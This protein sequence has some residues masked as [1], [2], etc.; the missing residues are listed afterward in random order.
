MPSQSLPDLIAQVDRIE[1]Q[2]AL[3]SRNLGIPYDYP[4]TT[5]TP[6]EVIE[7]VQSGNRVA[8][9]KR[10]REPDRSRAEGSERSGRRALRSIR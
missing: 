8:A 10:Y 6:P 3:I 2:V 4:V 9:V 7:L 5:E 1:R